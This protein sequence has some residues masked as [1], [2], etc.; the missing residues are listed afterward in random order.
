MPLAEC[1][2]GIVGLVLAAGRG[3]D[4]VLVDEF[5]EKFVAG[6]KVQGGANRL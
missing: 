3:Q 5:V 1:D 4:H 2:E 6:L